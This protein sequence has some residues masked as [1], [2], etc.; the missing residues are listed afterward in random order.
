MKRNGF[1]IVEVIIVVVV[2]GILASIVALGW[3]SWQYRTASNAVKSDLQLAA[4]SMQSYLNFNDYYPPNFDGTGFVSSSNV[5]VSL[6]TNTQTTLVYTGL[7]AD[8]N[9]QLFLNT[10]NALLNPLAN[11]TTCEFEGNNNGAKVHVKGTNGANEI[12]GSPIAST[13][14]QISPGCDATC[15]TALNQL[16]SIFQAQ[17]GTFPVVIPPNEVEMPAPTVMISGQADRYC[18]EGHASEQ[19]SISFNVN[20]TTKKVTAGV[21]NRTGLGY[22]SIP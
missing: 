5:S 16:K 7:T 17:G 8:Q 9:A 2:I 22:P 19:P 1:T 13:D 11:V 18:I 3:T 12:W 4:S 10:C 14:V 6:F 20:S 21:C 15:N